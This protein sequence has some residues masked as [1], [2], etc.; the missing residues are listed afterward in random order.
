MTELDKLEQK[1][2]EIMDEL[3]ILKPLQVKKP[4]VNS[5]ISSES[6]NDIKST[7]S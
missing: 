2:D 1:R 5:T 6:K 4:S 3:E 7:I